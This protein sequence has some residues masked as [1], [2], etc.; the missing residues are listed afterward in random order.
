MSATATPLDVIGRFFREGFSIGSSKA[1]LYARCLMRADVILASRHIEDHILQEML[2]KR[3]DSVDDAL[4]MALA[5]HGHEAKVLV[6]RNSE[7]LIPRVGSPGD[8]ELG[9]STVQD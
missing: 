2:T 9:R 4:E 8:L 5:K 7:D 3:A 6:L 1:W